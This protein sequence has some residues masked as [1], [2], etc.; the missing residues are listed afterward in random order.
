MNVFVD[1]RKY[2]KKSSSSSCKPSNVLWNSARF[3]LSTSNG[4]TQNLLGLFL[5]FSF[6]FSV[7][8]KSTAVRVYRFPRPFRDWCW[9]ADVMPSRSQNHQRARYQRNMPRHWRIEGA[10][11]AATR[12]S[13]LNR[14]YF[15]RSTLDS[16]IR[17]SDSACNRSP[18]FRNRRS[19][20]KNKKTTINQIET[21]KTNSYV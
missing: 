5:R 8:I 14:V 15:R 7:F 4:C 21:Y 19:V 20:A 13:V 18:L 1:V 9:W 17:K 10:L 3:G 2:E 11:L 6:F 12:E 16:W